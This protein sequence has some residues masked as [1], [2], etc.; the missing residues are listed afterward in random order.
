VDIIPAIIRRRFAHRPN[1]VRIA[2]NIGWL[3]FDKLLRLGVGL[4]VSVWLARYLGPAQFGILNY[5]IAFVSLFGAVATLGL[6]DIVVRDLVRE[7]GGAGATLGTAFLLALSGAVAALAL[8]GYA[9]YFLR[10]EDDQVRIIV[11]ILSAGL[12]FQSSAVIRYWFESRVQSRF[13]VWVEN[14]VFLLMAAIK[15]GLILLGAPL[16]AFAWITL[17]EAATVAAGLFY[18]YGKQA[19]RSIRWHPDSRRAMQLLHDAWPLVLSGIAIMIYM[20]IDQIML[21]ELLGVDEV[22][23]YSAALRISELWYMVPTIITAS[24]FPTIIKHKS[25]S[26]VLYSASL[27]RLFDLLVVTAIGIAIVFTVGAE[28]VIGLLYGDSYAEAAGV[29]RIH[30]WAGIFVFLGVAGAKWY[31]VE[32][33]QRLLFYL[34][35]AGAAANIVLNLVLI[36]RY[37]VNGAALATVAAQAVSGFLMDGT[38]KAARDLFLLKTK[39][40]FWFT[41]VKQL[42]NG[43]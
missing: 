14:S 43:S 8:I 21:G 34:T 29:L 35:V 25:Q 40:F 30:I 10:A 12:I 9:I 3:F 13:V 37:G 39:S 18:V 41:R 11:V 16:V 36:P 27:Q 28:F 24:V 2:D 33:L 6:K 4:F 31:L 7:P 38:R 1:F 20:R 26:G 15:V 42:C 19:P 17:A 22:G 23:V 5:A 32:N